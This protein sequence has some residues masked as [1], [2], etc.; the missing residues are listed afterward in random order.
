MSPHEEDNE[1]VE[2]PR[3][4]NNN[5]AAELR[6]IFSDEKDPKRE[7]RKHFGRQSTVIGQVLEHP[8]SHYT[9]DDHERMYNDEL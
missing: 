2:V 7:G 6:N 5:R 8:F 9:T 4:K 1:A 3:Q